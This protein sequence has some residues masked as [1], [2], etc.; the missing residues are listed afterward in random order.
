MISLAY[1]IG[2]YTAYEATKRSIEY[3]SDNLRPLVKNL[4]AQ[5]ELD[6][7]ILNHIW[8]LRVN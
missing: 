8:N 6:P 7:G 5:I 3:A 1:M 2:K 4:I